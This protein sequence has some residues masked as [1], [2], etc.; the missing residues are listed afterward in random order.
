M[1]FQAKTF[2]IARL[3]PL[4]INKRIKTH[5]HINYSVLIKSNVLF[6]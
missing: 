5:R 6:K 4:I 1:P 3:W 2:P